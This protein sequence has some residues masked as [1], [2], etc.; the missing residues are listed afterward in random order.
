MFPGSFGLPSEFHSEV[1]AKINKKK[2][3][4]VIIQMAENRQP[5]TFI[6]DLPQCV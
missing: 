6:W 2:N 4:L 5:S 3:Q 1:E